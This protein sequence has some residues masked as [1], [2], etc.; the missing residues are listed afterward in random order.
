MT[1]GA[2]VI[3]VGNPYRGDD[4][5]GP[6]VAAALRQAAVPGLEVVEASGE[7][8][9]LMEAWS[10]SERVFLVD[11]VSSGGRPGCVHRIDAARDRVPQDFFK[12]STHA[13]AVA[14]AV[15]MARVLGQLPRALI[16]YG[17]EGEDFSAGEDLTP[18]VASAVDEVTRR[19]AEE[20][21]ESLGD[22]HA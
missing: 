15:E 12:Y 8:A 17:I 9:A 14:E 21:T 20:V 18:A 19:I 16:I 11:A 3:G 4:G 7:G 13:F 2:R 22:D 10:G 6:S 1:E 5:A